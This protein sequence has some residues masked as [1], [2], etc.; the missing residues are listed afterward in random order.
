MQNS[1]RKVTAQTE[2]L[3]PAHTARCPECDMVT[4]IAGEIALGRQLRCQKCDVVLEIVAMSPVGVD[5]AFIAPLN[6]QQP[7]LLD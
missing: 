5:Y 3:E 2:A 1:S 4:S 7:L 6:L